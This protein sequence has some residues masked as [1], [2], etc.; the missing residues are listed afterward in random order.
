MGR[1]VSEHFFTCFD[2]TYR[3][4]GEYAPT[5]SNDAYC[6]RAYEVAR[7]MGE[8]ALTLREGLT[9]VPREDLSALATALADAAHGDP[10][11]ALALY[12]FSMVVGPRLLVSLRD[13]REY[14]DLSD[15]DVAW[16]NGASKCVLA[17][18]MAV[19]EVAKGQGPIDDDAWQEKARGLNRG[20]EDAGYAESFGFSR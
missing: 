2:T 15:E 14:A 18:M 5:F 20:L 12:C 11:G 13:A 1:P 7:A 6:V 4:L 3:V 9:E 8:V 17:E 10:S 16:S 19:G